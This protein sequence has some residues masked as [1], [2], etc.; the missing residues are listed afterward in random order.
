MAF[1]TDMI[2]DITCYT[3]PPSKALPSAAMHFHQKELWT[4]TSKYALPPQSFWK[5]FWKPVDNMVFIPDLAASST[6]DSLLKQRSIET[7]SRDIR[8]HS[9]FTCTC[10]C[11]VHMRNIPV[12]EFSNCW[13]NLIFTRCSSKSCTEGVLLPPNTSHHTW[14]Y[15]TL[16]EIPCFNPGCR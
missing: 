12:G 14:L 3:Q 5:H 6:L 13:Q 15:T 8:A 2:F 16:K 1:L 10:I 7:S 4:S 11:T 9:A